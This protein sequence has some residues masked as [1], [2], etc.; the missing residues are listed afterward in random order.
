MISGYLITG[1][2]WSELSRGQFCLASFYA[3]RCRR[4]LPALLLVLVATLLAGFVLATPEV[5]AKAARSAVAAAI[6]LSNLFFY[7]HTGYFDLDAQAQPLLHTWSLG[8]EEQFYLVWPLLLG[9]V[10]VYSDIR[11]GLSCW[12]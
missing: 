12:R 4:I 1:I 6:G 2:I 7:R 9:A 8:V 5:Y 11:S 10:A 3:R